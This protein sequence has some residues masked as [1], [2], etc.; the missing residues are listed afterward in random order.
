MTGKPDMAPASAIISECGIFRYRLERR[1]EAHGSGR[2]AAFIMVNPSTA[3]AGR[4]DPTI[5]KIRGFSQRHGIGRVIVG[6]KFA[7]RATDIRAL[8]RAA[9]AVGPDNDRHLEQI[10]RDADLHIVA[11]G[12]L[13]KLPPPLRTR[14]RDVAA[15]A[16]RVGCRLLCLGTAQDQHPLH[17]LMLS[18]GAPLMEWSRG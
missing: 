2:T 4:D 14:W 8:R 10:M 9:D 13:A 7:F 15:I 16:D 11:W 18:Y 5:R 1:I 6:N 17:P 12:A 3:D